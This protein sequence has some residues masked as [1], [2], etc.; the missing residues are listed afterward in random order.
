[1]AKAN[2]VATKLQ[3]PDETDEEGQL[4]LMPDH[5]QHLSARTGMSPAGLTDFE[6]DLITATHAFQRWMLRSTAATHLKDLSA[7]DALV[8]QQI[9]STEKSL[10]DLSFILNIEDTHVVAYSLRKLVSLGIVK[11]DKHGKEVLYSTTALGQEYLE[12]YQ[13]IRD[14]CLLRP[15]GDLQI[16][17]TALKELAQ[18][19]CK[20][21]GLYDQAARAVSSF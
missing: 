12:L 4:V 11:T 5:G 15:I 6:F 17:P 20:L 8:V 16:N 2:A 7:T 1:M 3:E 10:A 9:G 13:G 19:L 18:Y 14:E 21:S